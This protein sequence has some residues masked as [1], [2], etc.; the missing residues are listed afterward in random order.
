MYTSCISD[1]MALAI[2]NATATKPP[3]IKVIF[4]DDAYSENMHCIVLAL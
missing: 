3:I 1:Q 4:I 2:Q